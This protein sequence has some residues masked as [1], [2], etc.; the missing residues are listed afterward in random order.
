MFQASFWA[1]KNPIANFLKIGFLIIFLS[2][3]NDAKESRIYSEANF[4]VKVV[5]SLEIDYL[6]N[7]WLIN[8]D[9]ASQRYLGFGNGNQELV[10]LDTSG[11]IL[12]QFEVP[13]DGPNSVSMINAISMVDGKIQ[14]LEFGKGLVKLDQ[15]GNKIWNLRFPYFAFYLNGIAGLP[16]FN[17]GKEVA[18]LRPEKGDSKEIDWDEDLKGI[19]ESVYH[20]PILEIMDTTS[21]E[22]RQTMPFPPGS[23][24]QDG[25]FYGWTFPTVLRREKD[26]FLYLGSEMKFYH[27]KESAGEIDFVK[28]VSLQVKDA[29]PQLGVPFEKQDDF[30]D[31]AGKS[32]SGRINSI[33]FDKNHI[34]MIYEKGFSEDFMN[35]LDKDARKRKK[36]IEDEKQNYLAVFDQTLTLQENDIPLPKGLI[37]TNIVTEEGEILGLKNQDYF[38]EEKD[39]VVYYKLKVIRS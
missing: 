3:C 28:E 22:S 27:Y 39:Q 21:L 6:G 37:Y 31:I 11:V 15:K 2:S 19:F 20:A 8:Y 25:N 29:V 9:S 14:I 17:M 4:Q 24:Y 12:E 16:F 7:L 30:F 13:R 26:W 34:Y 1:I 23:F 32:Y 10:V 36:Q 5:D 35:G 38:E 18:F 33:T